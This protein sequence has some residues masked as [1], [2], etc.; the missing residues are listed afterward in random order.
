MKTE[1][2]EKG[3]QL[4]KQIEEQ[5]KAAEW[6][7]KIC[8]AVENAGK[9]GADWNI[10]IE[11]GRSKWGDGNDRHNEMETRFYLSD[12]QA[13]HLLFTELNLRRWRLHKS[14]TELDNLC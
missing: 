1:S 2:L 10:K 11:I 13:K 9:T 6:M 5:A 7:L 12:A 4:R 3:L 8:K 14:Q